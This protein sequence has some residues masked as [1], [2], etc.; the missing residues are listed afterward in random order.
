MDIFD[1]LRGDDSSSS[2]DEFDFE[3]TG[4]EIPV[5]RVIG[6]DEPVDDGR[7]F[8]MTASERAF[9]SAMI[10]FNVLVLGIGL[11]L[12]TGRIG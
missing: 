12:A 7:L 8:G 5:G 4:E 11:L 3:F 2:G 9:I 1:D 10:F 6:E